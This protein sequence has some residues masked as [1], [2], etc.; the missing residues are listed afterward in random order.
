MMLWR[1]T[2]S[3]CVFLCCV[4]HL[5]TGLRM[6]GCSGDHDAIELAE[7]QAGQQAR[8]VGIIKM[9]RGIEWRLEAK[10]RVTILASCPSPGRPCTNHNT[11]ILTATWN[12]TSSTVTFVQSAGRPGSTT[13]LNG[14]DLSCHAFRYH[15]IIHAHVSCPIDTIYSPSSDEVSCSV[16]TSTR[17]NITVSCTVSKAYSALN[18]YRCDFRQGNSSGPSLGTSRYSSGNVSDDYVNG[19]C[20]TTFPMPTSPGVLPYT[21]IVYPGV[22]PVSAPP[23]VVV[24]HPG[25]DPAISCN[26]HRDFIFDNMALECTCAASDLGQPQGRLQVYRDADN[27]A[28]VSGDFGVSSVR[29][30]ESSVSIGDNNTLY[31]C[32]LD[33][34][35][36]DSEDRKTT[37]TLRVASKL[38]IVSDSE[39]TPEDGGPVMDGSGGRG[40]LGFHVL[41]EETLHIGTFFYLGSHPTGVGY[42]PEPGLLSATCQQTSVAYKSSCV[43]V[44]SNVTRAR[45]GYYTFTVATATQAVS[46]TFRLQSQ[47]PAPASSSTLGSDWAEGLGVGVAVGVAVMAAM[48]IGLAVGLWR[49]QWRMPCAESSPRPSRN[50]RAAVA[51]ESSLDLSARASGD[52]DYPAPQDTGLYEDVNQSDTGKRSVYSVMSDQPP[53]ASYYTEA[54]IVYENP[55]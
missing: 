38:R 52:A 41:T 30:G 3:T 27:T 17:W 39:H 5:S 20:T 28:H 22:K 44:A 46:F 4:L 14:S 32:V 40:E 33:W 31:S 37:F 53:H 12:S 23:S 18:R 47:K 50:E 43:L 10:G 55:I 15:F 2:W 25:N 35:T 49:R 34:A 8:C 19:S 29:F 1:L 6:A 54:D 11:S 21:V 24:A 16:T 36:A 42:P 9:N 48:V 13:S 7:N 26:T 51:A 45:A